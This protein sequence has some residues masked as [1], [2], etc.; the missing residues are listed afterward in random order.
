MRLAPSVHGDGDTG[1]VPQLIGAARKG[2][3]A[4]YVGDG[5]NRWG[6]VDRQDAATL[7]RLALEKGTAGGRYHGVAD[8]G[9]PF[10]SIAEVIGRWLSAPVRSKTL[11]EATRQL[12]WIG[13]FV[14][15]DNPASSIRTQEDLGGAR[16]ARRCS[17]ISIA[18]ATFLAKPAC[19]LRSQVP[20]SAPAVV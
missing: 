10:R 11:P 17:K 16:Q 13:P 18:R 6:G 7:F 20:L 1:L 14:A 19:G 4:I 15:I 8:E 9:V 12:G 5:E 2:G 3:E